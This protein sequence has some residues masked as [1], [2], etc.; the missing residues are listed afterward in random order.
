LAAR[1]PVGMMAYLNDLARARTA[2]F[3]SVAL[4]NPLIGEIADA[5]LGVGGAAH[6]DVVI[7][8]VALRRGGHPAS[9]GLKRDLLDA[10]NLHCERAEAEGRR[11]LVHLPFGEQTRRW[12]LTVDAFEFLTTAKAAAVR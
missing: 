10:F 1:G 7:E 3:R 4:I 9:E 11:P 12:S 5:L 6:R 2:K 8:L